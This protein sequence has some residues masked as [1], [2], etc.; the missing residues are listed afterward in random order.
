METSKLY[1]VE[2]WHGKYL[3]E[4]HELNSSYAIALNKRNE[5]ISKGTFLRSIW[6]VPVQ[7][8]KTKKDENHRS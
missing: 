6:I 2:V 7:K 1:N 5:L 3:K 4:T 8:P